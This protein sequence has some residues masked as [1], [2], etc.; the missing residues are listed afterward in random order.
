MS[1]GYLILLNFKRQDAVW[2]KKYII[3]IFFLFIYNVFMFIFND[4]L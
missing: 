4:S 1:T 2:I 3:V